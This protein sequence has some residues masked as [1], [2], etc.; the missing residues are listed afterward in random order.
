MS[1][2]ARSK[3]GRVLLVVARIVLASIFLIAGYAK[4]KPQLS[5]HWSIASV[6]TSITLFAMQVDSY[7]MLPPQGVNTVAHVLPF[8]ELSLG[9]W[10]LTGIGLRFS[11]VLSVLAFCGFMT[12]IAWAYHRGLEIN[13]GCGIGPPEQVG[14]GALIRDGL[15][16][17]PLAL[18]V[19]IGAFWI[20]R[21]PRRTSTNTE[22]PASAHTAQ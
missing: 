19:T 17:L 13:C 6:R 4:V 10:L 12:A 8:F 5:M 3:L 2:H 1:A 9:L 7:Q 20:R 14:P 11:S 18:A 16:F 22:V 21:E 15:K